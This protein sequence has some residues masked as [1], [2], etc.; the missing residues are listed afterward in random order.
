M[1]R[2]SFIKLLGLSSLFWSVSLRE[3][4]A[5][6]GP[7]VAVGEGADH[8][9]I[10]RN[11]INALGGMKRFVKPGNT[12]VVKPNMGWDRT[13]DLA[14]NTSPLVVRAVVEECLK[15]GAKKVK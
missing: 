8:A 7:V 15:A 9:Q 12:V 14:A 5:A 6:T 11:A 1:K 10:T 3:L 2:R 13:A 4:F